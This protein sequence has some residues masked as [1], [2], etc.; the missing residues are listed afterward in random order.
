MYRDIR[1]LLK[2]LQII[3]LTSSFSI[4]T[5]QAQVMKCLGLKFD[6]T[7]IVTGIS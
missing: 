6:I 3:P 1:I 5:D 7:G 4:N 2:K